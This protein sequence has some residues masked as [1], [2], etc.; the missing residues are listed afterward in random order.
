[1]ASSHTTRIRLEKQAPGENNDSWGG[2]LNTNVIDL[3]DEARAG[4]LSKSV[5]GASDV[6]LTESDGGT[7]ESRQAV[8]EFTG[9]LTGSINV[10][11]PT[12]EMWWYIYNNTSGAFT[13]TVKTVAGTGILLTQGTVGILYC[14]GTNVETLFSPFA[15]ELLDDTTAAAMRTTLGLGTSAIVNTGTTSGLIPTINADGGLTVVSTDAGATAEPDLLVQRDSASP[16]ADDFLGRVV[17][18]G[19]D[20]A[21]NV[22]DYVSLAGQIIDPTSTTEDSR[23]ILR[24]LVASTDTDILT[25]G[26]GLQ[27]GA[28]TGADQG[29]GTVNAGGYYVDGVLISPVDVQTFAASGTWTK[30]TSASRTLVYVWGAGGAG[31]QNS[32]GGGGAGGGG[33]TTYMFAASDLGATETVTIGAGATAA[34]GDGGA[35]GNTT[36]GALLTGYGGGGGASVANGGGGGGGGGVFGAGTSATGAPGG[37][38][39]GPSSSV[40]FGGGGGANGNNVDLGEDSVYGG[41]GGGGGDV[42]SPTNG[43]QSYFGAGGGGGGNGTSGGGLGVGGAS[44]FGGAGGDGENNSGSATAGTVPGGGGGGGENSLAGDGADGQC[45]VISWI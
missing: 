5:A 32:D 10:I 7:D 22:E 15:Y 43:G 20:S 33:Y 27:V 30:P 9:A 40:G 24:A 19:E 26:P 18:Q 11:V 28:P 14:D 12:A 37:A 6:T 2:L 45:I 16:A 38:S 34:G 3:M 4:Y 8:L 29:A 13:L 25:Y 31:G 17:L 35:G 41:G 42:G 44:T 39:G 21:S 23:G 36:F 1:M